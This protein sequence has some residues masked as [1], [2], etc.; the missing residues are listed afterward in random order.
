MTPH[1]PVSKEVREQVCT[2][3]IRLTAL[4][5]LLTL[6]SSVFLSREIIGILSGH[7]R[8]ENIFGAIGQTVFILIISLLIYGNLVYQCTRLGHLRR[9]MNHS[10]ADEE[11][12]ESLFDGKP[13][14]LTILVPS[15]KENVEVVRRT[16]LSAAL[17]DYPDKHLVLLID[18]P[19]N[20]IS[21]R[22]RI[23]LKAMRD[24]PGEIQR[25]L[26]DARKPFDK[27]FEDY[28]E[29]R[30]TGTV[31]PRREYE[32]LARQYRNAAA[33]FSRI[34]RNYPSTDHGDALLVEKVFRYYAHAHEV[35]ARSL[36]ENA[37][38]ESHSE[39]RILRQYRRLT[40]LFRVRLSS[41]ERKK[42][43]NLSREANKA[44][45][46]NSYIGLIGRSFRQVLRSDGLHLEP[47]AGPAAELTV[48]DTD[49]LITLD[50]DS[51]LTPDYGIRLIHHM[52]QPG[53]V[54]VAV[55]QTPYN[56]IPVAPGV[57]ERI[58]GA[59]TDI[60]Y[61][62]HQG[63]TAY[64]GTYWVG[65]NAL[66]RKA[67]LD[68]I[69]QSGVERGFPV[70]RYVQDR[71]VIEDTESSID[72]IA[73]GWTLYNYPERM[74]FSATPPDFGSLVIQRRRWANGGL[75]ILPKLL[76]F[77]SRGPNRISKVKE[78]FFRFHYLFSITA[79]NFGL[80]VLFSFPFEENARSIWLPLT[81]L[82]YFYLYGR[83]LAQIGYR[84][85]D[86]PRVY[87]LNLLLIP[88][89]IAG[90]L[91]SIRQGISG[92]KVPFGRTPKVEN[93][94]ATP[95]FFIFAEYALFFLVL[96][97]LAKG[98]FKGLWIHSAFCLFN[99]AFLAYAIVRFIGLK[100]SRE[101][102]A[103]AYHEWEKRKA[104]RA[105]PSRIS[106]S[107]SLAPARVPIDVLMRPVPGRS[108]VTRPLDRSPGHF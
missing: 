40:S 72:L 25:L 29:R 7:L 8:E 105:A 22:D 63:F 9:E 93:R 89:N 76:G 86:L 62:I 90:V 107:S 37:L 78:G 65:A 99:L 82:P 50:A 61:L 35:K 91:D 85:I 94:T 31:D 11:E 75:L 34:S 49:F 12:L 45:N 70:T 77:L 32:I 33:W 59:T 103:L 92:R 58:A 21:P 5:F 51:L 84:W 39:Q 1:F 80:L 18:D 100:E 73:R 68:D 87:A 101:D 88:V 54:R 71:T 2:R 53:N 17:Q 106:L 43:V 83:D 26:D 48:P 64:G 46:L 6:A 47:A 44:M 14:S 97:G 79:V 23:G 28:L 20:S 15:Y 104:P 24:L 102:L 42:F 4:L 98:V 41:F 30:R 96:L 27:A 19:P 10:R 3:E 67:A 36:L 56:T 38:G 69:A 74:A 55:A 57:L 16:L 60:Q 52:N 108:P 13:P 66:L 81:A 95:V